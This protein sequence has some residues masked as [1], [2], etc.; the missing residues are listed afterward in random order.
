MSFEKRLPIHLIIAYSYAN[1][2]FFL[3]GS[4]LEGLVHDIPHLKSKKSSMQHESGPKDF[5]RTNKTDTK[6]F[7]A[8]GP[9][10]LL[11]LLWLVLN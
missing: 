10:T 5:A 2:C 6:L 8:C 4:Q 1:L 11:K 9:L 3:Q 7:P